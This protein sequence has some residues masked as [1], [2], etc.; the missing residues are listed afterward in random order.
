MDIKGDLNLLNNQ[1]SM[2]IHRTSSIRC[3]TCLLTSRTCSKNLMNIPPIIQ[4][5]RNMWIT[6]TLTAIRLWLFTKLW[7]KTNTQCRIQ[8]RVKRSLLEVLY[9]NSGINELL[10]MFKVFKLKSNLNVKWK[11]NG[12]NRS[13][14]SYLHS[15]YQFHFFNSIFLN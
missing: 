11:Q 7:S 5:T 15:T 6:S 8:S 3:L 9:Q 10:L 12:F 2:F 4:I 14:W 1:S 13:L